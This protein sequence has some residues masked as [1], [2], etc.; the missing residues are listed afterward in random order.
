MV[1]KVI[2]DGMV[3]VLVSPGYGAGWST[4]NSQHEEFMMFDASLVKAKESNLSKDEI[5]ELLVTKFGEEYICVLGWDD[6]EIEWVPVDTRISIH[7]YDGSEGIQY[8]DHI[9]FTT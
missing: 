8:L 6:T 3:A 5:A 9:G 2:R 1:E 7:E 4:W